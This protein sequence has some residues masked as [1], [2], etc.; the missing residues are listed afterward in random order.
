MKL[1][2]TKLNLSVYN[3]I[4]KHKKGCK[5]SQVAEGE[6]LTSSG[7]QHHINR[8]LKAKKIKRAKDGLLTA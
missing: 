6:G 3:I 5:V 7:A 1:Q 2:L 8:L 4:K